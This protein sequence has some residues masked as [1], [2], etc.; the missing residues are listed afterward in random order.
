MD[1]GYQR[2]LNIRALAS[3]IV[4]YPTYGEVGKRG[5]ITYFTQGLTTLGTRRI[6]EW[7]RRWR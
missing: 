2:K 3:M 6:M 1:A 7:L 4:P 5:A